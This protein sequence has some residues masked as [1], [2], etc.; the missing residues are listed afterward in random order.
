VQQNKNNLSIK[1]SDNG[2]G[3]DYEKEKNKSFGLQNIESR[4][5]A[6]NGTI[7]LETAIEEGTM[8]TIQIEL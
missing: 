7:T 1:I 3:F 4:I 5:T 8:Y 2:K 6:I